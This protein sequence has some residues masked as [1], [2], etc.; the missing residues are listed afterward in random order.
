[1][2]GCFEYGNELRIDKVQQ[3]SWLVEEMLPSREWLLVRI[4]TTPSG[5][6]LIRAILKPARRCT[7]LP[8]ICQC[9]RAVA[10]P[11]G[12]STGHLHCSRSHFYVG[13]YQCKKD[14]SPTA[15]PSLRIVHH[16]FATSD[17]KLA[18]QSRRLVPHRPFLK[19]RGSNLGPETGNMNCL[20]YCPKFH[21]LH[22]I[23]A[24][25]YFYGAT[26]NNLLT[27]TVGSK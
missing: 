8:L 24:S 19:V 6:S 2:A 27:G 16:T 4:V 10:S 21:N 7:G 14:C 11:K 26:G 23:L 20:R 5:P 25:P 15:T 13:L 3:I 1:V 18:V 9:R 22:R 17:F 12:Q